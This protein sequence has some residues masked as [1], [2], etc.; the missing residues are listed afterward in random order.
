MT[1]AR[2]RLLLTASSAFAVI[3]KNATEEDQK[4]QALDIASVIHEAASELAA[5]LP[6]AE[7]D[8]MKKQTVLLS[9]HE[10]MN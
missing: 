2:L 4:L 6:I 3:A 10:N 5:L 8:S 7:L 1:P 9:P